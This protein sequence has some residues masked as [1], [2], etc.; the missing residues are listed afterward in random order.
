[1]PSFLGYNV[2]DDDAWPQWMAEE[3]ECMIRVNHEDERNGFFLLLE[4]PQSSHSR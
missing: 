4:M 2:G 1:V 3:A